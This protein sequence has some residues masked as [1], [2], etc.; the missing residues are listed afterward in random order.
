MAK[1]QSAIT[2]I[3]SMKDE[4]F[5]AST[6]AEMGWILQYR[7][8]YAE[9]L[10]RSVEKYPDAI[11]IATE[12]FLSEISVFP[13][14]IICLGTNIE[15]TKLSLQEL[16]RQVDKNEMQKSPTIPLSQVKTTLV[17]TLDAGIGGSTC[18]MNI[19]YE[20]SALGSKT[21]L[22]DLNQDNPY[23]SQYFDIQRI[24]RKIAPS[25][26][27]FSLSEV[28]DILY[29]SELAKSVNEF[30]EVVIDFGKLL[31]GERFNSGVRIR[32]IAARWSVYSATSIF[33]IS[34]AD[35][36]SLT[37]LKKLAP[38]ILKLSREI[39][40][41]ILLISQGSIAARER[42]SLIKEAEEVFDC[43]V[44]YLPRESRML[45]RA[46]T[47]KVP[48]SQISPKSLLSRE[49]ASMAHQSAKQER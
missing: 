17:A 8:T 45:E 26:S 46:V 35:A 40:P 49:F 10:Q 5:V 36:H 23:L 42:K 34:R 13:N 37:R 14:P 29:F 30:D 44:R 39:R 18:A 24:N 22:L 11:I 32:E 2:A 16:L 43:A 28:A 1:T 47:E 27:G 41:T 33:I 15:L 19:A 7:A 48:L 6:L 25:Q 21:L 31:T 9:G 4:S 38:E 12:D 3:R 20:K